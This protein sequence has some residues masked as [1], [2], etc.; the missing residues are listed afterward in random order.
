MKKFDLKL[1][2]FNLFFNICET[3]IIFLLGKLI[4]TE[5]KSIIM[6]MVA[7][8]ICRNVC[9]K[10]KHFK[11]WYK[12]LVWSTLILLSL[13]MLLKIDLKIS[14]LFT[15]FAAIILSGRGDRDGFSLYLWKNNGEPS[16]YQDI[17]DYVKY[18]P[19]DKKLLDFEKAIEKQDSLLYLVYK[20]R[21]KDN[22]TFKEIEEKIDISDKRITEMLDK[23]AFAMRITLKI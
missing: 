21:F 4:G 19:L 23:I 16:K 14:I 11:K 1:F 5:T 22:L 20:Y 12:C 13:F 8:F 10:P 17:M 7:F 3:I 9:G 6:I 18:H 15:I 2:L